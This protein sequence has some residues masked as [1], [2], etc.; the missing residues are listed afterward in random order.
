MLVPILV[1]MSM[2]VAVIGMYLKLKSALYND[3]KQPDVIQ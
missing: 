2:H 3:H 1:S